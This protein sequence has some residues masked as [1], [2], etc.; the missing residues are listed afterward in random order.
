MIVLE[1]A[2]QDVAD[3]VAHP[4]FAFQLPIAQAR[5]IRWSPV[6]RCS[7]TTGRCDGPRRSRRSNRLRQGVAATEVLVPRRTRVGLTRSVMPSPS[8]ASG[9]DFQPPGKPVLL[10]AA[11]AIT[12][13]GE[14]ARPRPSVLPSED[15]GVASDPA[16]RQPLQERP[17]SS[18]GLRAAHRGS[19][20]D[21]H[22]AICISPDR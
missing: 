8:A 20:D 15:H 17:S 1:R 14:P 11:G 12:I 9:T 2:A 22:P 10:A 16:K 5:R 4:P 3:A 6:G 18:S 19:A 7:Q 13:H 21:R